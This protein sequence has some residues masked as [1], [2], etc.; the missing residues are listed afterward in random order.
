[1]FKKEKLE[2]VR[3]WKRA[4]IFLFLPFQ[5]LDTHGKNLGDNSRC[6]NFFPLIS[7]NIAAILVHISLKSF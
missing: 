3:V 5:E 2:K 6:D 4:G 7:R 1:M